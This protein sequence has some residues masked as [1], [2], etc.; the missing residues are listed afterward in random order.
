[1]P[2]KA[3][4]RQNHVRGAIKAAT[5][6]GLTV[7]QLKIDTVTG[8]LVIDIDTGLPPCTDEVMVKEI[9]EM[10]AAIRKDALSKR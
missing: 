2:N 6:A 9:A 1:M 8:E 7:K 4:F 5:D 10:D 3:I